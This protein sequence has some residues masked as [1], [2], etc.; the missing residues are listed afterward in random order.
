MLIEGTI[1]YM[2]K[3]F[4]E[5][6][7][8]E[9][10]STM[11]GMSL[12]HYAHS[13]KKLVGHSPI[14]YLNALR[15][16]HAKEQL[17]S[18]GKRVKDIAHAVGYMDEFYFSR[19][20]KKLVGT[21]PSEYID[22]TRQRIASLSFPYT[23]HLMALNIAPYAALVDSVRDS[24]RQAFFARIPYH[25]QRLK[26]MPLKVWL[27]NF[28]I[29]QQAKPEIV[30]CDEQLYASG[31]AYVDKIARVIVV[32]WRDM[33]WRQQ[34]RYIA[35]TIGKTKEA[36]GWLKSYQGKAQQAGQAIRA[37][38]GTA[39]VSILHI[40]L[41][42]MYVYGRRNGGAVLYFDLQLNCPYEPDSI[43]VFRQIDSSQ[44]QAYTGDHLVLIVDT[45]AASQRSWLELRQSM[46]WT[47]LK[48]VRKGHVYPAKECPWLDYSPFGH[49]QLI[50]EALFCFSPT[51][52]TE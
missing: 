48:A 21:A 37:A 36:E 23:G 40:M 41:G 10:L 14:D 12:W 19:K 11:A 4:W 33:D 7:S 27:Q 1:Q 49:E 25:L 38:I 52:S 17:L 31:A 32:P 6:I 45:D 2:E 22:R 26:Q 39:T 24:H 46:M 13:F 15:I 18:S 5:D 9:S 20:F 44:L 47:S 28:E 3:C 29:L 43:E 30:F 50:D 35:G 51:S 34:F 42:G 16:A 8:R